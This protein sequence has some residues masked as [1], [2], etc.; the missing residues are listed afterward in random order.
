MRYSLAAICA[1][2][3]CAAVPA[4]PGCPASVDVVL[5]SNHVSCITRSAIASLAEL[6]D[7]PLRHVHVV[8]PDALV[9]ACADALG[10]RAR[11]HAERALVELGR[12]EI[13]AV[14]TAKGWGADIARRR[15]M[16][17]YQQV[18][19]LT[20]PL[21]LSPSELA[22]HYFVWDGD[23][24]LARPYAVCV[25]D[26]RYR[27]D[28]IR[29][30]G[31]ARV[32]HYNVAT[33]AFLGHKS[34]N[35]TRNWVTHKMFVVKTLGREMLGKMCGQAPNATDCALEILRR[36]PAEASPALGLSEYDLHA[37]WMSRGGMKLVAARPVRIYR[38][39]Y[40][41]K[42]SAAEL[43]AAPGGVEAYLQALKADVA[44]AAAADSIV[45]ESH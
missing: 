27:L 13:I 19:K 4:A 40:S 14:L 44:E 21:S 5:I 28:F 3:L 35:A 12:D 18:L 39:D 6:L 42:R 10:K 20:L 45:I 17:Y 33:T 30:A 8:V 24:V 7:P 31:G 25:D 34:P 16:W 41:I 15:A 22:E 43:C 38:T 26:G 36:I 2:G 32:G 37:A 23:Q 9:P 29:G 11:C 1:L